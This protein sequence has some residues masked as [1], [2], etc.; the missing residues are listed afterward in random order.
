MLRRVTVG[1]VV[2]TACAATR[3]A[4]PQV[5]PSHTDLDAVLAFTALGLFDL[6]DGVNMGAAL[7]RHDGLLVMKHLMDERDGDRSFA[8][9]GRDALDVAAADIADRKDPGAAGLKQIRRI[10]RHAALPLIGN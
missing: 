7:V 2:T 6:V 8:N 1:R 5:D 3:L 10:G 4:G 9:R